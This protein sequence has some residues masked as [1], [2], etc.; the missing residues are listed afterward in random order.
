MEEL[1]PIS[2]QNG[3]KAV[4][5]RHLHAFLESKQQFADWIK[6]RI[7]KYDFVENQDFEVFH[8]FMK[9]PSGGRPLTEYA[10]SLNCAKEIAM[11]EGNAKGKQARQY[12][13]ECEKK[14]KEVSAPLSQLEIL[15]QSVNLLVAQE[16]RLGYVENQVN[17]LVQKQMEAENELKALPVSSEE[18]PEMSLRDR[19]RLLINRYCSAVGINQQ[20]AWDN[21]YQT[22]YYIYHVPIKSYQKL[23][24]NETWLEVAERKG[25]LD[26]IYIVASDLL[27]KKGLIA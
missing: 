5:A 7:Q 15:Q 20:T 3:K 22:L 6:D 10:L 17:M 12:F 16:R 4:S 19:I 27:R 9:N 23:S 18:V 21:V 8:N 2:E 11:V 25:H 24:K 14:S 1:I 26:K 13:I